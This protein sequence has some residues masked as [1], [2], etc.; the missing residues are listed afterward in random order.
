LVVAEAAHIMTEAQKVLAGALDRALN[1]VIPS[2]PADQA[3]QAE[4]QAA[5]DAAYGEHRPPQMVSRR[6]DESLRFRR[7]STVEGAYMNA[8]GECREKIRH[9]GQALT[10]FGT[11]TGNSLKENSYRAQITAQKEQALKLITQ[12]ARNRHDA[13]ERAK[14]QAAE[15]A[16]RARL[17][18]EEQARRTAAR[19]A[20]ELRLAALK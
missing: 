3:A 14:E 18:A 1:E 15:E 9:L 17:M 2:L 19:A 20:F 11:P 8:V 13:A 10:R 5:I 12:F 4:I 16:E 6:G 7:I